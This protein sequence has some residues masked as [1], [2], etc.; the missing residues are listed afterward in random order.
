M[1]DKKIPKKTYSSGKEAYDDLPDIIQ[2]T[3]K[4]EKDLVFIIQNLAYE[5]NRDFSKE[6]KNM[7]REYIKIKN[8][9]EDF[10]FILDK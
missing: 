7:L 2:K 9:Y 8:I 4:F 3:I 1:K 6:V 10:Y 5:H